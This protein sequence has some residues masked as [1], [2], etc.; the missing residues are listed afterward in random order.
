[1]LRMEPNQVTSRKGKKKFPENGKN[2][3]KFRIMDPP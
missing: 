1:M 2:L 3:Q